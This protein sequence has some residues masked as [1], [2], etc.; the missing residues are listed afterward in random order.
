MLQRQ[1]REALAVRRE[2]RA[3]QTQERSGATPL[4]GD[5]GALQ[6]ADR[7]DLDDM[8]LDVQPP[9][10]RPKFVQRSRQE[11]MPRLPQHTDASGS[12]NDLGE[13]L[14]ALHV[15]LDAQVRDSGDVSTRSGE[16]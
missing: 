13:D 5:E 12:R 1:A 4:D 14:E 7:L 8:E 2:Q 10:R 11:G 16:A 6:I 15:Q 9:D 3:L